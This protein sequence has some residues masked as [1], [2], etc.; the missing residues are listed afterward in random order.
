MIRAVKVP[1]YFSGRGKIP[2]FR[3]VKRLSLI[4]PYG[5]TSAAF[6]LISEFW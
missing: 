1:F 4:L 3:G 2:Q 6:L 5:K